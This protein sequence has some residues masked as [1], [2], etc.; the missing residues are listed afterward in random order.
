[1][2]APAWYVNGFP[3]AGTHLLTAMLA[4]FARPMP[5]RRWAKAG[6]MISSFR[7]HAWVNEWH[8]PRYVTYA[9]AHCDPG[10][11]Y[12]GHCGYREEFDRA[13][14]YA[15]L[16]MVFVYRD[17]RDVAVSQTFHI[18][19]E[20]EHAK[21][22]DKAAYR[23][24]GGFDEVLEAVI[25]GLQVDDSRYGPVYYPGVI[26]RW[27]QYRRWLDCPWVLSVRY[28]DARERPLHTATR[29]IR[30]G[31]ERLSQCLEVEPP[32][33][34]PELLGE[35]GRAMVEH[36]QDTSH[37]PTFRRGR[38]GDWVLHFT[39]RHTRMW[40]EHDPH[41]WTEQITGGY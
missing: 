37:S 22:L 24:L 14:D 2:L 39:E 36:A 23:Q 17:L 9:L 15:G 28:A 26:E 1:M 7:Y 3:K 21:H 6:T 12:R 20:A 31:M 38:V 10:Y 33:I 18:L 13:L 30:Y 4:P 19:N 34:P 41:G 16:A 8:N 32:E 27:E 40:R 11:Y 25:C 35:I 29:I 5:D